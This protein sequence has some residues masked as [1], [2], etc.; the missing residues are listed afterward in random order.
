MLKVLT[1]FFRDVH[2]SS[3]ISACGRVMCL[4]V[5]ELGLL[6]RTVTRN[7]LIDALSSL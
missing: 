1:V 5:L 7:T 2:L 4:C 6:A 3:V